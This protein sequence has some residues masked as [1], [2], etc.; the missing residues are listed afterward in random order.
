[1]FLAQRP[2]VLFIPSE[3]KMNRKDKQQR[4]KL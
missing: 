1:M 4:R 3:L 2:I